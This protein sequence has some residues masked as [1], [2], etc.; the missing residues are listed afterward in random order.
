MRISI[1]K[2]LFIAPFFF[3]NIEAF[4]NDIQLQDIDCKVQAATDLD[5]YVKIIPGT[6]G[7][8]NGEHHSY[9]SEA[10][11]RIH[12]QDTIAKRIDGG[13]VYIIQ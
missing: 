5:N 4:A 7:K 1:K 9:G 10:C 3:I 12:A 11:I 13:M 8:M 2:I 6:L